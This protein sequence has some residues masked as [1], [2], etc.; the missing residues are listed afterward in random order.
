MTAVTQVA[1]VGDAVSFVSL[2]G[3]PARK[4]NRDDMVILAL[5]RMASSFRV[6]EKRG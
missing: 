6:A 4:N 3:S 1:A 5:P 2:R